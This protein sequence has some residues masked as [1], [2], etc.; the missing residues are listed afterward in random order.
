MTKWLLS[1][2]KNVLVILTLTI[3][4]AFIVL[5]DPPHTLCRTQIENFKSR[6]IGRIYKNPKIKHRKKP[7]M[8]FLMEQCKKGN[9]PGS[10]YEFFSILRKFVNDFKI[11]STSCYPSLAQVAQIKPTLFKTY[12][13]MV[14]LAWGAEK[15]KDPYNKLQWLSVADVSLFCS[16]KSS[17]LNLYGQEQLSSLNKNILAH[18]LPGAS[19][20]PPAQVKELAL[21]S[22]ICPS[23]PKGG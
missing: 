5:Q 4:I 1:L 9:S 12:K 2:P 15:V 14:K 18:H 6:Q 17:I 13:L 22:E 8:T 19:K 23:T 3:A 21:T 7:L 16:L 20:M 10:C 11:V